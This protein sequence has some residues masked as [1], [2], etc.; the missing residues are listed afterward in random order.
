MP[1]RRCRAAVRS[2]DLGVRM[3]RPS[4]ST[5]P[6]APRRLRL[7]EDLG[8]LASPSGGSASSS[9]GTCRGESGDESLDVSL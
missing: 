3:D 9:E 6:S 8:A 1:C 4:R 2:S 7:N 5:H